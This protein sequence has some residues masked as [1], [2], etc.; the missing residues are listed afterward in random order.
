MSTPIFIG[1]AFVAQ[2]PAGGGIFW[3]PL[4]YLLGLRELGH[5][6]WWLEILWTRGDASTD[7]AFID[8]LF[9]QADA[10]GVA[11]R[12]VLLHLPDSGRDGPPGRVEYL[13][14]DEAAFAGASPR[15]ACC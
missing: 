9:R 2:Y 12:V 6:A 3:V 14:L 13:G 11:D 1:S 5:D 4:Q 10:L 15:R 8:A 7:R